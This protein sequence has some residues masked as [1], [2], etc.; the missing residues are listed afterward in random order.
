MPRASA[1]RRSP[2]RGCARRRIAITLT[3]LLLVACSGRWPRAEGDAA[4]SAT[5]PSA[6]AGAEPATSA[7]RT[8]P[9]TVPEEQAAAPTTAADDLPRPKGRLFD[10]PTASFTFDYAACDSRGGGPCPSYR[11]TLSQ[12]GTMVFRGRK[13][14]SQ[15]EAT[16]HLSRSETMAI[17]DNMIDAFAWR[18]P[19]S[20]GGVG[21]GASSSA[22]TVTFAGGSRNVSFANAC[23]PAVGCVRDFSDRGVCGLE[24]KLKKLAEPY[25][26]C[27]KKPCP[28]WADPRARDADT[29]QA[30]QTEAPTPLPKVDPRAP[31]DD[32]S[33]GRVVVRCTPNCESI[34]FD[35]RS[36]GPSPA[37]VS[38]PPGRY[39]V[40]LRRSGT[41]PKTTSVT[42]VAGKTA[43]VEVTMR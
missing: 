16:K 6:A 37:S 3:S 25:L 11:L 43:R 7:V 34:M 14:V 13:H 24:E 41:A 38:L 21:A 31:P 35:N 2:I 5:T 9:W 40:R 10:D 15:A 33:H 19:P 39:S 22:L 42:V 32:P 30:A 17:F 26:S 36:Y 28:E 20:N 8:S 27:G 12:D 1:Q 23:W 18:A 29:A 4:T